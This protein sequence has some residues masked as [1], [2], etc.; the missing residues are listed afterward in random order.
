M[1]MSRVRTAVR[2]FPEGA[3]PLWAR[4][5]TRGHA[6]LYE[7]SWPSRSTIDIKTARDLSFDER[8]GAFRW[9]EGLPN[10]PQMDRV[11]Q[12]TSWDRIGP[13]FH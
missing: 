12:L 7:E 4:A 1:S 8:V 3:E 10:S 13:D 6:P 2:F 11:H 5:V 9:L